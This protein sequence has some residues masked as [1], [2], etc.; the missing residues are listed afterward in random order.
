L[1]VALRACRES[2]DAVLKSYPLS[3]GS[4]VLHG[5]SIVFNFELDTLYFDVDM[6]PRVAQFLVGMSKIEVESI[7]SIA[8][9]WWME[10]AGNLGVEYLSE[11]EPFQLFKSAVKAMTALQ[12]F[13]VVY[14]VEDIHD[15]HRFPCGD[16]PVVLLER[17]TYEMEMQIWLVGYH[18]GDPENFLS[19]QRP[20][21][22]THLTKD[23]D[24][25]CKKTVFGWRPIKLLPDRP[26][27]PYPTMLRN[28]E[29]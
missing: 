25:P 11:D 3:Y 22:F 5:P 7:R 24:V 4:G 1:P 18:S 27:W 2:R 13:L 20:G 26:K 16:G 23:I 15:D 17:F 12:E 19:C 6:Q 28:S 21:D 8:V 14:N 10:D 29:S 9:D